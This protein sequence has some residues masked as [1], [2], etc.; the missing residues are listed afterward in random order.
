M[1]PRV[2]ATPVPSQHQRLDGGGKSKTMTTETFDGFGEIELPAQRR[3][4]H[5]GQRAG[6]FNISR[7][8]FFPAGTL[9]KQKHVGMDLQCQTNSL[10]FSSAQPHR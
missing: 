2:F 6:H 9:I 1:R 3:L 8:G 7:L 4:Q 10:A 5:D